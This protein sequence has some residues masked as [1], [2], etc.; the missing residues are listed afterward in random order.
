MTDKSDTTR[1]TVEIGRRAVW[2]HANDTG[3][4]L[5]R[6]G[7]YGIDVHRRISEQNLGQCLDCTHG[8]TTA[9]DWHRFQNS[10]LEHHGVDIFAVDAP[11][12]VKEIR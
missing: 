7:V 5:G 1:G 3:E 9:A 4:C 12:F 10:M 2:V 8:P 6:F 11:A